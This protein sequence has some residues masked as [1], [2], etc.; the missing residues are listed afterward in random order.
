MIFGER[1]LHPRKPCLFTVDINDYKRSYLCEL[2]DLSVGGAL[3]EYPSHFKPVLGKEL[4]LNICFR[5]RPG[6]VVVKGQI[7]RLGQGQL[8]LVFDKGRT[9]TL[10][11]A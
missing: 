3:L 5:N 7:V 8:A 4:L 11:A 9:S 10:R 1:R 2:K 6:E